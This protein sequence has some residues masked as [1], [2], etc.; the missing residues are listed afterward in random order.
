M[1]SAQCQMSVAI[2]AWKW[3]HSKWTWQTLFSE[4]IGALQ[5]HIVCGTSCFVP[6]MLLRAFVAR[7]TWLHS[8]LCARAWPYEHIREQGSSAKWQMLVMDSNEGLQCRWVA[9]VTGSRNV[10]TMGGSLVAENGRIALW[11]QI[12]C[13]KTTKMDSNLELYSN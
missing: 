5:A 3:A 8:P 11:I 9:W 13:C 7:Q 12:W 6:Q 4:C 10:A 1:S 2:I